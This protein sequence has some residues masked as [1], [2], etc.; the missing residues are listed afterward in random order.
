MASYNLDAIKAALSKGEKGG[1]TAQK[2]D[3]KKN[4]YW[5]PTL[6]THD[7][8]FLPMPTTTGEPFLRVEYYEKLTERRFIA[9]SCFGLPDP[10]KDQFAVLRKSKSKEDWNTTKNLRPREKFYATIIVRGEEDKGPQIWELTP[11]IRQKVYDILMHKDNVDEDMFSP[12]VG[13]DFT[14]TISPVLENGKP[15]TFNGYPMKEYG[16]Q[17]RKK[18]SVLS[19]DK[20]QAK[21]WLDGMPNLE[22][23][24]RQ[25][26]YPPEK[27]IEIMEN[28]IAGRVSG[29]GGAG[30]SSDEDG[31]DHNPAS[32]ST[33]KA[34]ED[35][36]DD[37][38]S[39]IM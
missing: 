13:Y 9:P 8:R 33:T 30:A 1:G 35:K 7:V 10:I 11:A 19:K 5:K 37:A 12:E 26:C 36:L 24:M 25:F 16:L 4:V 17:P 22:E 27:L 34:N 14:V 6:G 21:A 3:G 32:T 2:T 31:T 20:N 29:T 15:K 28:Y 38:F 18:P 39:S 23:S